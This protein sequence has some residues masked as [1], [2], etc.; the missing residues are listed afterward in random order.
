MRM[1]RGLKVRGV[2]TSGEGEKKVE[3]PQRMKFARDETFFSFLLPE[4]LKH[5]FTF[6]SARRAL[7]NYLIRFFLLCIS[8]IQRKI[9]YTIY[10]MCS[11]IKG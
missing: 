5:H 3:K 11:L 6:S 10:E 2:G 9:F 8:D 7:S 4:S 1:P